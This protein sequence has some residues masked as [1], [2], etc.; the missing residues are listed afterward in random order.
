MLRQRCNFGDNGIALTDILRQSI[1]S[2]GVVHLSARMEGSPPLCATCDVHLQGCVQRRVVELRSR[3]PAS[4]VIDDGIAIDDILIQY[5]VIVR[6]V[7]TCCERA[8]YTRADPPAVL[9]YPPRRTTGAVEFATKLNKNRVGKV[10]VSV[11]YRGHMG[12]GNGQ[13]WDDVK[14]KPLRTITSTFGSGS[15]HPIAIPQR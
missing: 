4:N 9:A 15:T 6:R 10:G 13:I 14:Q 12:G 2:S 5:G 8:C 1:A 11:S 7:C 3:H